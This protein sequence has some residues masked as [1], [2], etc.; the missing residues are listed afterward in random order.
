MDQPESPSPNPSPC[1]SARSSKRKLAKA[2]QRLSLGDT[3]AATQALQATQQRLSERNLSDE[4]TIECD[5]EQILL[6]AA[7]F[8]H[9]EML[10]RGQYGEVEKMLHAP[11]NRNY[12]VKKLRT[13][14]NIEDQK[15][16]LTDLDVSMRASE[17]PYMVKFYGALFREGDVWLIMEL[18]DTS[19]DKFYKA[20]YSQGRVIPEEVLGVISFCVL[21]AL[22]YM[23]SKLAK[24]H[25]DVKPSNILVNR[26]GDV[27]LCDFGIS[28]ELINSIANSNIG[29]KP[30]MAPE[31]I[32]QMKG[33]C[34]SF[35]SYLLQRHPLV[36]LLN[37]RAIFWEFSTKVRI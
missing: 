26:A 9:V 12:A 6:K 33:N 28:G 25:R 7:D 18:M 1:S 16:T 34:P 20:V 35:A 23:R 15:T 21:Q 37:S 3:N 13:S 29:C 5:G 24:M 30:Y 4:T 2:V 27:K 11:S 10:G 17:C 36:V 32:T 8:Q 22:E 31:R 19:F 14:V